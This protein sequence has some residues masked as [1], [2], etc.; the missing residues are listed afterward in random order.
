MD[1]LHQ[2]V[3]LDKNGSKTASRTSDHPDHQM[4]DWLFRCKREKLT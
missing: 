2:L 3:M 1:E 4:H